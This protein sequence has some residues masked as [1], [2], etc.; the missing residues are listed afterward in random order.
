MDYH[1]RLTTLLSFLIASVLIPYALAK[2]L[3]ERSHHSSFSSGTKD[4]RASGQCQP[5]STTFPSSSVSSEPGSA[6][7]VGISPQDSYEATGNGLHMYLKKPQ[8]TITRS[9]DT[10]NVLGEGATVNSTFLMT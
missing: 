7:F 6:P 4:V 2:G 1:L 3:G 8:G 10:N 5:F 9:G